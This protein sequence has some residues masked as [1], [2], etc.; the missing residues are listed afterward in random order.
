MENQITPELAKARVQLLTSGVMGAFY[1]TL[2]MSLVAVIRH[3]IKTAATDARSFFYNPI[4][5]ASLTEEERVG[6]VVHEVRHP[7]GLHHTRRNGRDLEG[8]NVATDL[9]INPGIL[10]DGFTL[11]KGILNDPQYAGLSAEEIFR[12]KQ[13]EQQEKQN[14]QDDS[15]D[16]S[17]DST[18]E[19]NDNDSSNGDGTGAGDAEGEGGDNTSDKP[20][21]ATGKPG[22]ASQSMPDPGMCGG[23]IDAAPPVDTAANAQAETDMQQRIRQAIAVAK[24]AGG[25]T[26]PAELERL[27]GEL[28]QP[29][30]DA[31]D[32]LRRFIDN[33][34]SKIYS[35]TRPNKRF[36]HIGLTLPSMVPDRPGHIVA[37]VDVSGSLWSREAQASLTTELQGALDNGAADMVTIVYADT[38]VTGVAE[39]QPGDTITVEGN[40]GGGTN[41]RA[42]L[43]WVAD[44]VQAPA[45]ILYLT[46]MQTI[47]FGDEPECPIMWL[48]YGDPRSAKY[49]IDRAPFGEAVYLDS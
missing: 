33:A 1:G 36:A 18:E 15:S 16:D 12:L 28:N 23:I 13:V 31:K 47:D 14:Q 48:V 35:W 46:D 44:H 30:I 38:D 40:G 9:A 4:W 43:Q 2:A 37:L 21:N 32:L 45:A 41:F 26:L 25:G 42:P 7:M 6:V 8:W 5:F 34:T 22:E 39:Y 49:W 24:R 3:D 29:K 27:V 19:S 20:N 17:D 10:A 11:P